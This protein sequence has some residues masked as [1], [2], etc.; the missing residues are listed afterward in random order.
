M[1][2]VV[3]RLD[4][5][6]AAW[7]V[8]DDLVGGLPTTLVHADYTGK[9]LRHRALESEPAV[10]PFDWDMSGWGAPSATW[11]RSISA[12]TS[13]TPDPSGAG[14]PRI[15]DRLADLGRAFGLVVAI[16]W[17]VPGLQIGGRAGIWRASPP[18][19]S[20]SAAPSSGSAWRPQGRPDAGWA[21]PR[22]LNALD[23]TTSST[24]TG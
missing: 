2:E 15:L 1:T 24:S 7:S 8:C 13:S 23:V 5:I 6:E 3:R 22:H 14:V 20:D 16:G 17:E 10:V 18:S 4:A 12:H 9:N 21:S 19:M 11:R